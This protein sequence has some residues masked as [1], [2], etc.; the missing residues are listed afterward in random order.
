MSIEQKH[1]VHGLNVMPDLYNEIAP[2]LWQ[3]GTSRDQ[4]IDR[5]QLL[6]VFHEVQ[7]PFDAV[8]TLYAWAAPMQWGVE[9]RRLGFPDG[10]LVREYIPQ[11]ESIAQWAHA[12]R[13]AGRRVLVRCAGG[14]NRSGLI[15]AMTLMNGGHTADEA[16]ALVRAGRGAGALTNASFVAYLH[17]REV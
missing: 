8:A 15:T 9:E 14:M 11:L 5:A 2:G 1:V 16:I 4:V 13:E 6:T 12:H 10:Q 17:E 3:G 7:R